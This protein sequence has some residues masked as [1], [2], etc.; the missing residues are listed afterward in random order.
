M[1]I[2]R[3]FAK[4]SLFLPLAL[5]SGQSLA[6]AACPP[7]HIDEHAEVAYVYDG[8]TI[9]LKDGRH[10]RLIGINTPEL[11]HKDKTGQR[12]PGEDEPLAQEA[13][14]TV[15]SLLKPST[16]VGLQ[17]GPDREDRYHRQLA[18]VFLADGSS[19]EAR[20]LEA[21]LATSISIPPNVMRLDCYLKA[22]KSAKRDHAG[23]WGHPYFL[24][25]A[26]SSVTT[27]VRGYHLVHGTIERVGHSRKSIW[28]D[29]VGG[30]SIRIPRKDLSHFKDQPPEQWLHREVT[31]RGWL[32]DY[33]GEA[34]MTVRHPAQ[35]EVTDE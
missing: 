27:R 26:A 2:V 31:V 25:I 3:P 6:F 33:R 30:F 34:L 9:R 28:L 11:A 19:L 21:G 13:R 14:Q 16:R 15:M 7:P 29:F 22:E 24:P 17:L 20:L 35:I 5:L 32:T 4:I 8:D 10:I 18:H 12:P 23:I 1:G